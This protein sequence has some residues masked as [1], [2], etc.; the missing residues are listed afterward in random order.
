MDN[1]YFRAT[2][3]FM[4]KKNE[5]PAEYDVDPAWLRGFAEK[6]AYV[7]NKYKEMADE[8]EK[9]PGFK[10]TGRTNAETGLKYLN[11]W[12]ITLQRQVMQLPNHPAA[13]EAASR[14]PKPKKKP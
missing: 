14:T 4:A 9:Q 3:C 11:T 2:F 13:A 7:A 10:V 8:I 5:S 1:G 12:L 6:V